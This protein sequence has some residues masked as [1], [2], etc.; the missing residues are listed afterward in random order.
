PATTREFLALAATNIRREL[1]DL[2]RHHFGPEGIGANH[3][4]PPTAH[5]T[6]SGG[7]RPDRADRADPALLAEGG[8]L[9]PL[10]HKLPHDAREVVD[11]R[12]YHGMTQKEVAAALG[13]SLKTVK[14]RWAS[15]RVLLG[16]LLNHYAEP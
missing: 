4:T 7:D 14:R 15:A 3:A 12:W 1:I 2:A 9:H 16:E 11:L 13:V 5:P 10:I 8:E 6:G